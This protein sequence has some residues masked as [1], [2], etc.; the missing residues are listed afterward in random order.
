MLNKAAFAMVALAGVIFT[1]GAHASTY[2]AT[3]SASNPP[4]GDGP[5]SASATITTTDA[6]TITVALSNLI[7]NP[8]GAGQ[9]VSGIELTL[10]NSASP[11][12]NIPLFTT[13]SLSS[14]S[15]TTIDIGPGGTVSPDIAGRITHWGTTISGGEIVLAT[16]GKD[17]PPGK[18]INLIIG[19]PGPDGLYDNNNNNNN[20]NSSI[21]GRNPQIQNTGMF[22]LSVLGVTSSTNVTGVTF[23][24]GTGP[25]FSLPDSLIPV[26]VPLPAALPLFASGLAGLGLLG[27]RRKKKAAQL[28]A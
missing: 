23:L 7:A 21:A 10:N 16:A 11:T 17:A 2:Q 3:A 1:S 9:L 24:F 6:G 22:V 14:A 13:D 5:V 15:G 27:W 25:D 19:P 8:T 20:A 4:G 12:T 18:P 26:A 28:N